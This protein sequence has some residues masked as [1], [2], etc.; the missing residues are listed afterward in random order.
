MFQRDHWFYTQNVLRLEEAGKGEPFLSGQLHATDEFLSHVLLDREY[1][2][3]YTTRFPAKLITTPLEWK[4]MILD[5]HT[6]EALEEINTW[7]E[8]Q[9]T[10][11]E[12][13]GLKRIL[14]PGFRTLFYGSSGTGKTLA[15]TLLGKKNHMDV[16]RMDLSLI[17]SK[18]IEET[19]KDLDKMFNLAENHNWILFFD[20]ADTLFDKCTSTNI[21]NNQHANLNMAY[22]LQRIEDF[23]GLVDSG[24]QPAIEY[25]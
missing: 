5:C 7:I 11:L 13:W 6:Y 22:L 20:G 8:C 15:A 1:K 2:P 3:D 16:Y 12:D 24:H 10:I 25:R 9:H 17:V 19:E 18:G 14:K 4:D 21:S 23:S